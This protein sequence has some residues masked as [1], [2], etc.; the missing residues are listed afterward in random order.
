MEVQKILKTRR[1]A[2]CIYVNSYKLRKKQEFANREVKFVCTR[3]NCAFV[4][5]TT[6]DYKKITDFRNDH[7]IGHNPLNVHPPCTQDKIH[8]DCLRTEAERKAVDEISA[9]PSKIVKAVLK[10]VDSNLVC[11]AKGALF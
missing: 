1:D 9:R 8:M 4:V 7:Y 3:K 5:H 11:A 6:S 2:V 10:T